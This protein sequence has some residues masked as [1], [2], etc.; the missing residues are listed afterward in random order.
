MYL[1]QIPAH[2]ELSYSSEW[3]IARLV[4]FIMLTYCFQLQPEETFL[5][6]AGNFN[7]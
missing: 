1:I 4:V 2:S 7:L 6:K 5:K 3:T